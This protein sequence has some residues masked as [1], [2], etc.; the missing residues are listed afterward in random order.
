M[1]KDGL[2][3][4]LLLLLEPLPIGLLMARLCQLFLTLS[5][6]FFFI[7]IVSSLSICQGQPKL[8]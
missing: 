8:T 6:E 5:S 7:F 4:M 1:L 3:Q 2:H